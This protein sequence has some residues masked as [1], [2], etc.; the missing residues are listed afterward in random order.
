MN[1]YRA[2]SSGRL[3]IDIAWSS[4]YLSAP[5]AVDLG[6]ACPPTGVAVEKLEEAAAA[7][8]K[9]ADSKA[10]ERSPSTLLVK[11][12]PYTVTL[13]ELQ[14]PHRRARA[15]WCAT[16]HVAFLTMRRWPEC[17]TCCSAGALA[18]YYGALAPSCLG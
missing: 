6:G 5:P 14:V 4:A 11:N 17:C 13:Q 15:H 1:F 9:A 18:H 16:R 12:L 3:K 8:G 2:S 10:V 7:S